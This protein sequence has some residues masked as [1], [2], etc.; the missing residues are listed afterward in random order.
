[1]SHFPGKKE[2]TMTHPRE[3][4]TIAQRM[5]LAERLV[6]AVLVPCSLGILLPVYLRRKRD[7][8][9]RSVTRFR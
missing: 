1:M 8:K 3:A 7:Y 4:V 5:P 2:P 9:R 6:W